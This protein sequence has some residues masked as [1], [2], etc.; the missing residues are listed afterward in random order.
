M[1][2]LIAAKREEFMDELDTIDARDLMDSNVT[3]W[4]R[5]S[6]KVMAA[7]FSPCLRDH[8]KNKSKWYLILPEYRRIV[9]YYARTGINK[10]VY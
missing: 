4:R 1:L 9:D 5:I 7:G 2:V 3:K 10:E 6:D 8:A